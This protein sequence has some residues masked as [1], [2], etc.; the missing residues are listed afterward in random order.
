MANTKD[1][2][3]LIPS[4]ALFVVFV[5]YTF[6]VTLV[7]VKPIGPYDSGVGFGTINKA[8]A[9]IIGTH[10]FWYHV[11]NILGIL[12]LLIAA[13]FGVVGVLQL[14]TRHSFMKVDRDILILGG[15]Y[16]IVLACY[17]LFDKFAINYRPV[18]MD[19][20]L[21]SSYPSSHTM[22]ACSVMGTAIMQLQW[23]VKDRQ[24]RQMIQWALGFLMFL[25]VIGRM[26]SGVHWFTDIIGGV[27]LSAVLVSLYHWF[28]M[29]SGGPGHV[30]QFGVPVPKGKKAR[31]G[32]SKAGASRP[33]TSR[34]GASR[35][36]SSRPGTSR[37]GTSRSGTS[38]AGS[39][40]PG[41]YPGPSSQAHAPRTGGYPRPSSGTRPSAASRPSAGTRTPAGTRPS[42]PSRPART[43]LS[44]AAGPEQGTRK[45]SRRGK[46]HGRLD[47]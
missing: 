1:N 22:L 36:G 18:M 8:V 47:K 38:R 16:I 21:E 27:L 40:R 33:G 12:A 32:A 26:L 28:V 7:D 20:E 34:P 35:T 41:G 42:A 4:V 10:M 14:V 9:D 37:A 17:V 3:S 29:E 5:A 2:N 24:V 44:D 11:T 39:S 43:P 31:A 13:F 45:T 30:G 15:F 46:S 23:K 6:A 19:G 25:L